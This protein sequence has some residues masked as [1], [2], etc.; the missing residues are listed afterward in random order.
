MHTF[1]KKTLATVMTLLPLANLAAET[2]VDYVNPYIGNISHLLVPTYPTVHLPNSML[3][4]YPER[5]DFTGEK[6][7]GLPVIVTSHRGKSAFNLS[8][9]QGDESGLRPVYDY[10]YDN[11]S[12]TPYSYDCYFDEAEAWSHFVPS[13]RSAIYEIEFDNPAK[14]PYIILNTRKGALSYDGKAISGYQYITPETKVYVYLETLEK[15][16]GSVALKKGKKLSGTK[17][18]DGK[19]AAIALRFDDDTRKLHIRYGI[20]FIDEAQAKLNLSKEITDFDI[21][22]YRQQAKDIWNNTLGL[23]KATSSTPQDLTLFYTSLYRT[24]ERMICITEEGNRYY[25]AFDNSIHTDATPFYTDDWIWDTYRAVH[26]LRALIEPEKETDMIK[27]FLRMGHQ[28]GNDWMPTFPEVTGDSRRMNSNHGVA[29]VIDLYNKGIRDFDLA[30]AYEICKKGIT[31]KSLCPWVGDPKGSVTDF[32][33]NNGYIPAIS[34]NI[35]DTNPEVHHFEKRQPVAVTLGTAYDEWCLAGIAKELGHDA[36]YSRF[37]DGSLN[38]RKIYNPT[39]AFFHPKDSAGNFI[40]PFDYSTSGGL[41]AR[42]AYGEN[43]GWVYRWD[44]PHNIADLVTMMGGKDHFLQYLDE[45]Y[46][47]PLPTGKYTFFA[48]LP[49][50]TGNVGMFSMA[51]EPSMHIPYLYNYVGE[52]WRTQK[53]IRTLLR[54]WFRNDLMGMPGDED[55]G[56]MSAFVV[57]SM[58]GFYPVTPGLPMYVIGSPMFEDVTITLAGNR[59]FHIHADNYS[60]ENKYIQSARLNGHDW[61]QSWISHEDIAAGGTLE[62]VMGPRPN[63]NWASASIPPSFQMP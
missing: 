39:T 37:I 31:E 42:N 3:R 26:P 47:T 14:T 58:I 56:G 43:N 34:D 23:I 24:Y 57:F 36:D 19:N 16:I 32:Y 33:W 61:E 6:V 63:K 2:P 15:P 5:A 27:S 30:Y 45:M 22:R 50:H 40:K 12:I 10:T 13:H 44:V 46:S 52:P 51:N 8:F 55:G 38:Y 41:G 9:Y 4:V 29:T 49:D 53:R 11:E 48:Q 21:N 20:S 25:S 35:A 28:M 17:S 60:P 1:I 62:F 59:K 7:N 18:A 54:Q